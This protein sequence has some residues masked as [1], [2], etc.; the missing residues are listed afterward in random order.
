MVAY[1]WPINSIIEE[2]LKA[3]QVSDVQYYCYIDY[4]NIIVTIMIMI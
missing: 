2:A 4:R 3:L 1:Q